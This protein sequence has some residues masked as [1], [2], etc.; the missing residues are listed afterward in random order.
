MTQKWKTNQTTSKIYKLYINRKPKRPGTQQYPYLG[1]KVV[2]VAGKLD[3]TVGQICF[4]RI[5]QTVRNLRKGTT[6]ISSESPKMGGRE[7]WVCLEWPEN[8]KIRRPTVAAAAA[9]AGLIWASPAVVRSE[10]WPARSSGGG[11]PPWPARIA[12]GWL[13]TPPT[14]KTRLA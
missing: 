2:V 11:A 10:I 5:F 4:H 6:G 13:E 8:I 7:V 3:P 1:P 14:A 12:R 9:F